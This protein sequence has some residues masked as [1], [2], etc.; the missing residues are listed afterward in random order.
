[1]NTGFVYVRNNRRAK[2]FVADV[3]ALIRGGVAA[4]DAAAAS[5][6]PPSGAAAAAAASVAAASSSFES[7]GDAVNAALDLR[8]RA[9]EGASRPAPSVLRGRASCASYGGL[10]FYVLSPYLFQNG[11]HT[12]DLRLTEAIREPPF[13]RHFTHTPL[14]LLQKVAAMKA[15]GSW[16]LDLDAESELLCLAVPKQSTAA[17]AAA[18]GAAAAPVKH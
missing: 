18:A 12:R 8:Y 9:E 7:D 6:P 3:L 16:M 1:M 11:A 4:P 2:E 15:W 13:V 10:S 14:G 17:V 5:N